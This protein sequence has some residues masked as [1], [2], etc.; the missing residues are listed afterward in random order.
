MVQAS[1]PRYSKETGMSK[2]GNFISIKHPT[3]VMRGRDILSKAE[4]G[5]HGMIDT[6]NKSRY[7]LLHGSIYGPE[8]MYQLIDHDHR[9]GLVNGKAV[10]RSNGSVSD[11]VVETFLHGRI[12]NHNGFREDSGGRDEQ[13]KLRKCTFHSWP[14]ST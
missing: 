5:Q 1:L 6:N 9:L 11:Y 13:E 10:R 8:E 2:D 4:I 14:C 12:T 7:D 3:W